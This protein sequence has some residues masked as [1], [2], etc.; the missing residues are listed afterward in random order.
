MPHTDPHPD[1]P[2]A[3][4]TKRHA[5]PRMG[6]RSKLTLMVG[7]PVVVLLVIM[8]TQLSARLDT[9]HVTREL[10]EM[11]P[12]VQQTSDLVHQ[13]RKERGLSAILL[14]TD[15][16]EY[17][18]PADHKYVPTDLDTRLDA[19]YRDTDASV[20]ALTELLRA[21]VENRESYLAAVTLPNGTSLLDADVPLALFP[22]LGHLTTHR[23]SVRSLDMNGQDSLEFYSS[24]NNELLNL[25]SEL[26]RW[27][28]NRQIVNLIWAHH[29][30]AH[31]TEGAGL[32]RAMLNRAIASGN[33]P[34]TELAVLSGLIRSQADNIDMFLHHAPAN[35]Q[36]QYWA[37]FVDASG[38]PLASYGSA[39]L[40]P[41][42]DAALT[43]DFG[44]LDHAQWWTVATWRIDMLD[45]I[46]N[47]L[48]DDVAAE[49][50]HVVQTTREQLF[51]LAAFGLLAL[52]GVGVA[53]VVGGRL[54]KR[55]RSLTEVTSAISRGDLARRADAQGGDELGILG[56]AFNDM[57]DHLTKLVD[58]KDQFIATVSHELRTPLTTVIGYAELL[59]SE[60]TGF[61]P[62]DRHEMVGAIVREAGELDDLIQDLLVAARAADGNLVVTTVHVDLAAQIAQVLE[63]LTPGVAVNVTVVGDSPSAA[64][65]P[66][67]VRQIL[68]N[69]M[70]NAV[71]YGG[72]QITA[73]LHNGDHDVT[74][75]VRD[76]GSGVA[77]EQQELMFAPY[78]TLTSGRIVPGSMGL[79]LSV[80]RTLARLMGGDLT[81]RYEQGESLFELTLPTWDASDTVAVHH[82]PV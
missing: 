77:A 6:I 35:R 70:M 57:A 71:K 39:A 44:E 29:A 67:R 41:Y 76:N 68:R 48:L 60:D 33:L 62:E 30:I 15:T 5:F 51:R 23:Q 53:W 52:A 42:R 79:G 18:D 3:A 7:G 28:P 59:A 58:D 1:N 10:T 31:A 56:A 34:R 14:G 64:G 9:V 24:L 25:D 12:L 69:L 27:A 26:H 17:G 74:I 36:D 78:E 37:M 32:E 65:D 13:I 72:P 40:A 21:A 61:T 19:Q 63:A 4:P 75:L 2:T 49:G 11:I 55:S 81:Y 66:M 80:S 43:D 16:H 47:D 45:R 20:A 82:G 73:E 38:A 22:N 46:E 54:A 50:L 8:S